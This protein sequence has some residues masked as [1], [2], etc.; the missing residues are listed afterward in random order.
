MAGDAPTANV[1]KSPAPSNLVVRPKI[2][3]IYLENEDG[4]ASVASRK[5]ARSYAARESHARARRERMTK[6]EDAKRREAKRFAAESA[7]PGTLF[8]AAPTD[9]FASA[10][11]PIST[12]E[13]YLLSHYVSV[14]IGRGSFSTRTFPTPEAYLWGI[15]TEWV[16]LALTDPGMLNGILISACRSLHSLHGG[17]PHRYLEYALRYKMACI[18]SL[19]KAISEEGS[20]PQDSSI[21]KAVILASDEVC[22]GDVLTAG[23]HVEAALRMVASKGGLAALGTSGFLAGIIDIFSS[24]RRKEAEAT[25]ILSKYSNFRTSEEPQ[26]KQTRSTR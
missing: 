7:S 26:G 21:A 14:V 10:A 15:K 5:T 13:H 2:Q 19:N 3:F 24:D 25:R 18:V 1:C 11:R 9:P 17:G 4:T 6:Y 22:I 23:Q 12:F 20:N 16:T 8:S